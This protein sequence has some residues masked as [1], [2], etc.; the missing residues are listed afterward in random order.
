MNILDVVLNSANGAAVRELGSQLGLSQ[1]Q[2]GTALSAVVPVLARGVRRNL[3]SP[4]G[5]ASLSEA[6]ASGKHRRYAEDPDAMAELS[7]ADDGNKILEH[8]LGGKDVSRELASRASAQTGIDVEVLKRMLP[9]AAALMMGALSQRA[10]AG[11][12]PGT[13]GGTGI[14]AMLGGLGDQ[15]R[16][17]SGM[18]DIAG[19]MGRTFG[20]S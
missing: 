3:Q 8:I 17:G 1:A 14:V 20:R 15:N 18:D 5:V 7:T 16:D 4:D 12:A 9:L 19:R 2:T 6:L 10:A 11:S 13:E